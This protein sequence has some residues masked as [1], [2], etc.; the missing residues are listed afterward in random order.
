MLTVIEGYLV[1][2]NLV[3][4]I[5]YGW[6]KRLAI[7]HKYRVP[8]KRLIF[9][10]VIGGSVGAYLGMR[11]FRHKTKHVKFYLGVPAILI[12]QI[13]LVYGV[14]WFLYH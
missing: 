10:A 12:T 13:A 14:Y 2:I 8:E 5:M 11:V 7:K 6:D 9:V 3:A 4:F 1:I